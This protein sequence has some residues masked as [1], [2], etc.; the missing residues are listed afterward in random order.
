[1]GSDQKDFKLSQ[2]CNSTEEMLCKTIEL[3]AMPL[4]Q[5]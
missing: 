2:K 4:H 5:I 1:M 3:R